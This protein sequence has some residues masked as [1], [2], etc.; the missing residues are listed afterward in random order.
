MVVTGDHTTAAEFGDHT[1][2]PVPILFVDVSPLIAPGGARAIIGADASARFDEID[3]GAHGSLG[4]F[5]GSEIMSTI[6]KL[7]RDALTADGKNM[8]LTVTVSAL[9]VPTAPFS[10]RMGLSIGGGR[11]LE[12]YTQIEPREAAVSMFGASRRTAAGPSV[13]TMVTGAEAVC[14]VLSST[15][16]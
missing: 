14:I 11:A 15:Q 9:S 12:K 8:L 7:L 10:A 16:R 2:E 1:C 6:K 3:I 13:A 5:P 4:R